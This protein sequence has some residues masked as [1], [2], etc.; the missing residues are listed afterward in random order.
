MKLRLSGVPSSLSM[1]YSSLASM[2]SGLTA[3]SPPAAT[4]SS[5]L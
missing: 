4:I 5:A 2:L 1:R 3:M